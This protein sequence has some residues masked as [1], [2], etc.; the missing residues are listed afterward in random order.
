MMATKKE[1][2]LMFRALKRRNELDGSTYEFGDETPLTGL[3]DAQIGHVVGQGYYG[4]LTPELLTES[5]VEAIKKEL[6]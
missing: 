1:S 2:V 5:Q 3:T 6:G 4:V